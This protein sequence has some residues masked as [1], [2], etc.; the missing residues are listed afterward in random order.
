MLVFLAIVHVIACVA[1]IGLSLMQDSKGGGIFASQSSSN[2]VLGATGGT[3]L[4]VTLTKVVSVLL[5]ATCVGLALIYSKGQKSVVDT[6]V[7]ATT[8]VTTPTT[9]SDTTTTAT[10]QA[11]PEAAPSQNK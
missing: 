5:L 6:G 7:M 11:A 9:T 10:P 4:L 1:L 2:S 8:P 3:N